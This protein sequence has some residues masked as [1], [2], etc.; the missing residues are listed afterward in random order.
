MLAALK[1]LEGSVS[2]LSDLHEGGVDGAIWVGHR[3]SGEVGAE[4]FQGVRAD[5]GLFG[6]LS[7]T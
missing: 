4:L 7:K 6:E 1:E 3:D 5:V 2:K